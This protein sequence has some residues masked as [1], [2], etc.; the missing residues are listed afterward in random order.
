MDQ[1]GTHS[2]ICDRTDE[3]IEDTEIR[4]R[5]SRGMR[6]IEID[7][8][9]ASK[10]GAFWTRTI[11]ECRTPMLTVSVDV[12]LGSFT[13]RMLQGYARDGGGRLIGAV[14]SAARWRSLAAPVP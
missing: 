13:L 9:F 7:R 11:V 1:D 3:D 12:T 8:G 2:R 14:G 4:G 6:H 10:T 5:F